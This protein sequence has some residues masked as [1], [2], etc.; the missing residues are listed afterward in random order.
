LDPGAVLGGE[1]RAYVD[2]YVLAA[3]V[4]DTAQ[5]QDLRPT[6]RHLQHFLVRDL[7]DLPRCWRDPRVGGVDAVDI[8]VDLTHIGVQRRG[9]S[10]GGGV[11]AAT[12]DRGD[13][14]GVLA[15]ALEAGHDDDVA[16]VD[17]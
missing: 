5:M 11:R 7:R 1:G 14:L 4:L 8:G 15:D 6:G 9:Q 16:L 3:G 13:V 12:T 10:N 2:G 17:G